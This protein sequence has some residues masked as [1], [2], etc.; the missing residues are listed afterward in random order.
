L[1]GHPSGVLPLEAEVAQSDAGWHVPAVSAYRTARR[2][3][4]GSVLVPD[5]YLEPS[6]V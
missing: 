3:M 6:H 1:S 4:E 2:L 5:G